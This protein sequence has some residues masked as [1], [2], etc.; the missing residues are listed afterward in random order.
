MKRGQQRRAEWWDIVE[1]GP[2]KKKALVA[3]EI[4]TKNFFLMATEEGTHSAENGGEGGY[5]RSLYK[6]AEVP[7][8]DLVLIS[9]LLPTLKYR[10]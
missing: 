4:H 5:R 2:L 7:V 6:T 8:S 10:R 3:W 9:F 1:G